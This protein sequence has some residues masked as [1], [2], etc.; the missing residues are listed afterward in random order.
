MAHILSSEQIISSLCIWSYLQNGRLETKSSLLN[1]T[2][3]SC[4]SNKEIWIGQSDGDN[5]LTE[6]PCKSVKITTKITNHKKHA[7]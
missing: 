3:Q 5:Y 7:F 4:E 6:I 2:I 1:L